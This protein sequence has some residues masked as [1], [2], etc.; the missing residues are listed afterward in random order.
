MIGSKILEVVLKTAHYE[1]KVDMVNRIVYTF[2]KST[3]K[4]AYH[5]PE[6]KY[7]YENIFADIEKEQS[8]LSTAIF[9]IMPD[10]KPEEEDDAPWPSD[11]SDS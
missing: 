2:A 11:V 9:L 10:A 7:T 5:L 8:E 4:D 6:S 1:V 3:T